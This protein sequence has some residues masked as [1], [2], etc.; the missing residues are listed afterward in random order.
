MP[1]HLPDDLRHF[2]RLTTGKPVIMGRRTFE[3]IGRP[4]PQR[5]NI[6]LTRGK[7]LTP[8]DGALQIA[9]DLQTARRLAADWIA[10]A[11]QMS[12][13]SSPDASAAE[14]MVIGGADVYAQAL[15]FADRLYLTEIDAEFVGNNHFPAFAQMQPGWIESSREIHRTDDGLVYAF[16]QYDRRTD[17]GDT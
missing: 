14:V 4:L 5:L 11:D 9:A 15:P 16:V 6:V 13:R 3:S 7:S 8:I 1:W 10:A 17:Q 2:R 12:A